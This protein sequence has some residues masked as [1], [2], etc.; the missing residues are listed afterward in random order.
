MAASDR[1]SFEIAAVTDRPL[2][3]TFVRGAAGGS[4]FSTSGWL[5]CAAGVSGH[6]SRMYGCYRR[7]QLVAGVSGIELKRGQA[8]GFVTPDLSPHG[9]FVFRPVASTSPARWESEHGAAAC[10]LIHFLTSEYADIHLTHAPAL[11]DVRQFIWSNWD[12]QPRYTYEIPL[13]DRGGLWDKLERRTRAVIRR[14]ESEG[15]RI[16]ATEDTDLLRLQYE[17][18]YSSHEGGTPVAGAVVQRF[19]EEAS[20]SGFTE[21]YL[22]EDA[23][24]HAASIVVFVR[25]FD[26]IY[27]WISGADPSF[28]DSGATSLLYW[29]VLQQVAFERFDFVGANIPGIALFKRGFGGDLVPYFAVQK[30]RSRLLN[31]GRALRRILRA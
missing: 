10:S 11:T 23:S 15:F 31:A 7:G 28:R 5:A 24:G 27:A 8:K 26:R 12:V 17:L 21:T 19:A 3:D 29:K 22:V 9:G 2:W 6:E 20:K 16:R 18:V 14:A 30:C 1:K 13:T 4:V 25:G